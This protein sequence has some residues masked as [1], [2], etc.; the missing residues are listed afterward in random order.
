MEKNLLQDRVSVKYNRTELSN[1]NENENDN[2]NKNDNANDGGNDYVMMNE[3]RNGKEIVN[4]CRTYNNNNDNN[5]NN[6]DNNNNN[7][8]NDNDQ[9]NSNHYWSS[10]FNDN[11]S[12]FSELLPETQEFDKCLGGENENEVE[13]EVEVEVEGSEGSEGRGGEG[14]EGR[15]WR[16]GFTARYRNQS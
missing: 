7:N 11:R 15:D 9:T 12:N 3:N 10:K 14:R 8:N 6:Y 16:Q 1:L 2:A 13:V 4:H 5:N